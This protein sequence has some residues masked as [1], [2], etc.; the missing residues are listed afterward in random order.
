M[1]IPACP[2]IIP[3]I[4]CSKPRLAQKAICAYTRCAH[5]GH[6]AAR[7][8]KIRPRLGVIAYFLV[9]SAVSPSPQPP[10]RVLT[11]GHSVSSAVVLSSSPSRDRLVNSAEGNRARASAPIINYG[12][13]RSLLKS[14]GRER[15]SRTAKR[16]HHHPHTRPL[17][18]ICMG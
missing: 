3:S 9:L 14:P 10:S 2:P 4:T 11:R 16:V 17:M 13:I 12:L 7:V 5:R 18:H 6:G 15:E 8:H 1:N